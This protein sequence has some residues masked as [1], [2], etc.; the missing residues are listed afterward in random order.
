M[1]STIGEF[2]HFNKT[3]WADVFAVSRLTI[4]SWLKNEI[5]PQNDN[6]RKI[7]TIFNIMSSVADRKGNDFISR[8][9]LIHKIN[10]YDKSLLEIF[11][12]PIDNIKKLSDLPNIL[13]ILMHKTRINYERM[14]KLP[15][16]DKGKDQ[17]LSYNLK[18]LSS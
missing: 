11:T 15:K 16:D 1:F 2:F 3:E 17:N 4:Y 18:I 8:N 5:E 6:S 12:E 14:D 9:Y 13:N 7:I 10:K